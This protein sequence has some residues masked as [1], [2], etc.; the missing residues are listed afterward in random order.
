MGREEI[1]NF[2]CTDPAFLERVFWHVLEPNPLVKLFDIVSEAR[3]SS[4]FDASRVQESLRFRALSRARKLSIALFDDKGEVRKDF[5]ENVLRDLEKEGFLFYPSGLNDGL[6]RNHTLNVLRLLKSGEITQSLKRFHKFLPYKRSEELIFETL[7]IPPSAPLTDAQVRSAILCA[8]LTPLRQNVGSC[9]ATAPAIII[10]NDHLLLFLDDLYQLLNT[11][12]LKRTFGGIEYS[13]PLS[14]STGMGDLKKKISGDVKGGFCP[15]VILALECAGAIDPIGCLEEKARASQSLIDAIAAKSTLTTEELIHTVLLK[16]FSLQAEDVE[17][18][19][20]LEIAQ[21]KSSKMA[22]GIPGSKG[23]EKLAKILA[24]R[25]K[26]KQCRAAFKGMCDN[27]LLKSWEFTLASFSEVKMEFSRW[28]LYS[29]LGFAPEEKGGIGALIYSRIDEKIVEINKKL[30]EAQ[31]EYEIA[32]DQLRATESLMR[33]VSSDSEARR[34]RAELQSRT[35]HMRSCLDK[36]DSLYSR[37][38]NYSKLFSFLVKQY[39]AKF[40]EYFQEIYDA[41]MQ[42][43]QGVLYDDSPAGFRL[44]YKHGRPDPSL[45]TLIY[46]ADQYI[47]SLLDFFSTVEPQIAANCDWDGGSQDILELSAAIISHIRTERFLQTSLQRMAKAHSSPFSSLEKKPWAYTSG[48]TMTTL[49]KTYYCRESEF[50]QEE[51]WVESES[52]LLIF[53][54]DTL[55]SLP[56]RITDPYLNRPSKGMLMTSPSHAFVLFPGQENLSKGWQENIFTYTWVRDEVFLPSQKF[57]A[58]MRLKESAQEFLLSKLCQKLPLA[59]SQYLDQVFRPKEKKVTVIEWRNQIIDLAKKHPKSV[60]PLQTFIDT[61]DSLLYQALPLVPGKEWKTLVAR[62]LS[63]KKNVDSVLEKF[64]D[65]PAPLM[66]AQEIREA[67]KGCYLL[68]EKTIC[69][70][71]DLHLFIAKQARIAGLAQLTPL[72]FADTNW[73]GNDFGF[74]VNPGTGRLEMWR[75][76]STL[77]E[78]VP[79]SAWKHWLNGT[80]RK[81][82][83]IFT[84]PQE[85]EMTSSS[86]GSLRV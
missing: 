55:K 54:L 53:I 20:S 70:P 13:V 61:L 35:Y 19:R 24:F 51:K 57:Y 65:I 29:S 28:N 66:T 27:A 45:W 40:P 73:S 81:T 34:L 59:L 31:K 63:D 21:F 62:I 5:L 2:P 64:P 60:I 8:C 14:P 36:R 11:G 22:F 3:L 46:D 38:S 6:L 77:S 16:K 58:D 68:A 69:L 76:D 56:P 75:L 52:E 12:K 18:G 10:Q 83:S 47:D 79:M 4:Y 41:E 26:E 67:S 17:Q 49:L 84:R 44:V 85:Y 7:G 33:N 1:F 71:F 32:F 43:F 30:E 80:D 82:W 23:S 39:D 72:L 86:I 37:G 42:D 50:T 74:V 78:G 25:E 48:G 15:G 9:F